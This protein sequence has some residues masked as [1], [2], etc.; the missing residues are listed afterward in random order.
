MQ[1]GRDNLLTDQSLYF[2]FSYIDSASDLLFLKE[3]AFS[4]PLRMAK[5][6]FSL[7]YC[8][9]SNALEYKSDL[10]LRLRKQYWVKILIRVATPSGHFTQ[11]S[12]VSKSS[13]CYAT[14]SH[15]ISQWYLSSEISSSKIVLEDGKKCV[16]LLILIFYVRSWVFCHRNV[17]WLS[18]N[19]G[20]SYVI[21]E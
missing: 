20:V 13:P 7:I 17:I 8:F 11:Q 2:F 15:T 21:I 10:A 14:R 6:Y 16:T 1:I 9:R 18:F 4:G 3:L 19:G 12:S 5:Q